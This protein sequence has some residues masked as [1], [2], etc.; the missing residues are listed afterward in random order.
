MVNDI[1]DIHKFLFDLNNLYEIINNHSNVNNLKENQNLKKI[2]S[3]DN[4]KF[5]EYKVI[6]KGKS[7]EN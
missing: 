7:Y 1:K 3:F 2:N 4:I 5:N 6:K